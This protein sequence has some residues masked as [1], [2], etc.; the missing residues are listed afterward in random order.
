MIIHAQPH[1]PVRHP[2]VFYP[3]DDNDN[4]RKETV[5]FDSFRFQTFFEN[6]SVRFG[7]VRIFMISGST[8]FGLRFSDTLWLGPVRFG[9]VPR[10]VPAGSGIKRFGSVRFGRFSSVSHSLLIYI[11][12]Y[13]YIYTYILYINIYLSLSISLSLYIYIYTYISYIHIYLSLSISLSLYIYIYIYITYHCH[14]TLHSI[15]MLYYFI[16]YSISLGRRGQRQ[17]DAL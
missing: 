12:I 7:S 16:H 4:K 11:Y 17:Y 3:C 1:A 9:S 13:I 5:R 15:I 6:L 2:C 10:P 8:R 14:I